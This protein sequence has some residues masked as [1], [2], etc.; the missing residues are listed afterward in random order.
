MRG[1]QRFIP[2]DSIDGEI[3]GGLKVFGPVSGERASDTG[4][5]RS[6]GGGEGRDMR[7]PPMKM[8]EGLQIREGDCIYFRCC[9]SKSGS[10][11]NRSE[12][13]NYMSQTG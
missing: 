10:Y 8:R 4:E 11:Q 9:Q 13:T 7:E 12:K 5:G 2:E 3:F 6:L 1:V